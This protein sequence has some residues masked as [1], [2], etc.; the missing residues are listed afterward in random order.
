MPYKPQKEDSDM[1]DVKEKVS[2]LA[3]E[4]ALEALKMGCT[5]KVTVEPLVDI[6]KVEAEQYAQLLKDAHK[7]L[8]Q[9]V[10]ESACKGAAPCRVDQAAAL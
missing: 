9:A 5:V 4:L 8:L 6:Q 7:S 10:E 2:A 1:E 3:T